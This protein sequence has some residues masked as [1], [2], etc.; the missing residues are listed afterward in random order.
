ME[1]H[2]EDALP[3]FQVDGSTGDDHEKQLCIDLLGDCSSPLFLRHHIGNT[4]LFAQNVSSVELCLV[5]HPIVSLCQVF[6]LQKKSSTKRTCRAR[7]FVTPFWTKPNLEKTR[8][9]SLQ[10]SAV[11]LGGIFRPSAGDIPLRHPGNPTP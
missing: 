4:H 10:V 2:E 1:E 6:A 11:T 5:S 9:T 7:E 3:I 8:S